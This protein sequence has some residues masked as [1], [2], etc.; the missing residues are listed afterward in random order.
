MTAPSDPTDADFQRALEKLQAPYSTARYFELPKDKLVECLVSAMASSLNPEEKAATALT[1]WKVRFE[2]IAGLVADRLI[3]QNPQWKRTAASDAAMLAV[4]TR[5]IRAAGT[6]LAALIVE[7]GGMPLPKSL[8]SNRGKLSQAIAQQPFLQKMTLRST[9]MG[10]AAFTFN[11]IEA[12]TIE[13]A[14][15]ALAAQQARGRLS[16]R[17]NSGLPRPRPSVLALGTSNANIHRAED[18]EEEEG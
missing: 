11:A 3:L 17:R 6:M 15:G 8:P 12:A 9:S 7:A 16:H 13:K 14:C 4:V 10:E 18:D 1:Q 5:F 2:Q